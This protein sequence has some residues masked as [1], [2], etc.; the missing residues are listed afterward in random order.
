MEKNATFICY[1]EHKEIYK[2]LH[3]CGQITPSHLL[4]WQFFDKIFSSG[5]NDFQFSYKNRNVNSEYMNI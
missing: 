5:F 2:S 3:S 4:A 1:F